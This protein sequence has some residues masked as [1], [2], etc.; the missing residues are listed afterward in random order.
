MPALVADAEQS[1]RATREWVE[2]L[3]I[4]TQ[5]VLF[6]AMRGPDWGKVPKLKRVVRWFRSLVVYPVDGGHYTRV[7]GKLPSPKTVARQAE[8]LTQHYVNHFSE[9]LAIVVR[10]HPEKH[11]RLIA[12]GYLRALLK[13]V[14]PL[15]RDL[16]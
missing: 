8:W 10:H 5:C 16:S 4:K 13:D 14:T 11:T 7:R 3:P 1:T 15:V 6:S 2:R 9:A 12:E